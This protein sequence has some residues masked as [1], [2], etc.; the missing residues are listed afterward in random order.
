MVDIIAHRGGS[1]LWP[2]NSL[3]AFRNSSQL[4]V[5]GIEFDVHRSKDGQLIVIHD[6]RLER[7]STGKGTLAD[8]TLAEIRQGALRGTGG[9]KVP[10]LAE[11]LALL[12]PGGQ[13]LRLELKTGARDARYDGLEG[14]V[15]TSLT[16]WGLLERTQF[17]SFSFEILESLRALSGTVRLGGVVDQP[18]VDSMGGMDSVIARIRN[19]GGIGLTMHH[20]LCTGEVCKKAREAGL[21]TTL[22][23]V[24]DENSLRNWLRSD[25]DA[26][27]TDQPELALRLRNE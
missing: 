12:K 14:A 26:I 16:E 23:T 13:E 22:Y 9:E 19:F 15:L 20:G 27:T 25:V 3:M 5:E 18:A 2:E 17:I 10:T 6:A 24:N 1:L 8:M 7:T 21:G 11:V 4:A